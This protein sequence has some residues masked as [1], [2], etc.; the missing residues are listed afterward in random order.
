M[1]AHNDAIDQA[2]ASLARLAKGEE[3]A[4][5]ELLKEQSAAREH[6]RNAAVLLDKLKTA[7]SNKPAPASPMMISLNP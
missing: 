6:Q 5:E 2:N 7:E 3:K 4:Q 1:V